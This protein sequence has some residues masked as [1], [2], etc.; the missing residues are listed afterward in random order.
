MKNNVRSE[1]MDKSILFN[2]GLTKNECDVYLSLLQKEM[3]LAS[4]IA[5]ETKISRPHIYD[6]L[7]RLMKKGLAS[8]I[9]KNNRRYFKAADPKELLNCI[10]KQ[11]RKLEVEEKEIQELI[12]DL[13][14]LAVKKKDKPSVELYEGKEGF[15][16]IFNDILYTN[17]NFV[18]F[19][20]SGKFETLL[21]LFSKHFIKRRQQQK[22]KAR[23]I[24]V[25]GASPIKTKLNE[26]RTISKAFCSP[27]TTVVYGNKVAILVWH[28]EPLGIKID[29]LEVAESYKNYFEMLWAV[30]KKK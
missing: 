13:I 19:G 30:S 2:A 16:T 5:S 9:I 11:K 28:D 7:N 26:Y 1:T 21:P 24:V 18:A 6:S 23:L 15:K 14:K 8:Y 29:S 22:I 4:K 12:P 3:S 27:S 10:S 20:A 17:K 25:E